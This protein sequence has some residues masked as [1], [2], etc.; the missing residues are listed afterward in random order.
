[1]YL[2]ATSVPSFEKYIFRSTAQ[3]LFDFFYFCIPYILD[4]S[5]MPDVQLA[6]VFP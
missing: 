6:S 2:F 3:F 5:F 1:M 4:I